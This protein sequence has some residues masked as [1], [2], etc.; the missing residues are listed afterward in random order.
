VDY[1]KNIN[2]YYEETGNIGNI[3]TCEGRI[4]IYEI[5]QRNWEVIKNKLDTLKDIYNLKLNN[6]N[7]AKSNFVDTKF[8]SKH[9]LVIFLF[10]LISVYLIYSK[11]FYL[12]LTILGIS[13]SIYIWKEKKIGVLQLKNRIFSLLHPSRFKNVYENR[14]WTYNRYRIRIIFSCLFMIIGLEIYLYYYHFWKFTLLTISIVPLI[15]I[16]ININNNK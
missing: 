12:A 15:F 6:I 11:A 16:N 8:E 4:R 3:S 13:A 1:N 9:L 5:C 2:D 14:K 10:F 7:Q